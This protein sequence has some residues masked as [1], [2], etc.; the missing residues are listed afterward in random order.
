MNI[1]TQLEYPHFTIHSTNKHYILVKVNIQLT[2]NNLYI[3][4]Y[5]IIAGRILNKHKQPVDDD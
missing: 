1:S 4:N 3:Y 5:L 2:L